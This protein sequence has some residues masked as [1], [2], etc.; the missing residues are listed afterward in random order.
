[1]IPVTNIQRNE[2]NPQVLLF[3]RIRKI[4]KNLQ[5]YPQSMYQFRPRFSVR[6]E[7]RKK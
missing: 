1:M 6:K 2:T 5:E 7:R 3:S 4:I